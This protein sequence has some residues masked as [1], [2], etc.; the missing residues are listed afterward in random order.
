MLLN[1]PIV[2]I[3]I[4]TYNRAHLL[5]ETLESVLAQTYSNWECIIVDD[6]STDETQLLLNEYS[7]KDNRFTYIIKSEKQK[8]GAS[9]SRN[10]GLKIARGE[11][12]QFLDSDD[13][14]ADNKIQ[15]QIKLLINENKHTVCTCKWGKFIEKSDPLTLIENSADYRDFNTI[16]EYFNLIGIYG[17]FFPPINFLINKELINQSG[18]W[19]ES[20]TVNDDGEF[21]FRVLLNADKILFCAKTYVLYRNNLTDNLSILNSEIKAISLL[22]S[23]KIIEALYRTKYNEENSDYI[24]KKKSSVYS[25]LKKMYPKIIC[26][27]TSF[28]KQQIKEDT[29]V[30]KISK[31]K[32]R[33]KNRLK[34]VFR[35]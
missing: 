3:I 33:I 2:S 1:N 4:P 10:L 18:Y 11:F 6:N 21:F 32:K 5:V 13:L 28:F 12:I 27:N 8:K 30:K 22:N 23:W 17:G 35:F 26:K 14:L 7:N 29:L 16:K 9:I 19:N 15:E 31:L 25:E 24:N 34:I 20:L